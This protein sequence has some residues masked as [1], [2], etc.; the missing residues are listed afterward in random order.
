MLFSYNVTIIYFILHGY[1]ALGVRWANAVLKEALAC[2]F[3]LGL[4]HG[5]R[6]EKSYRIG[7]I[8][9]PLHTSGSWSVC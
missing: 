5:M 6:F 7:N 3:S 8:T 9:A 4:V 2:P 1:R